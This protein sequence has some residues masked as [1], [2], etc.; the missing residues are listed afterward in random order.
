MATE[1]SQAQDAES[2][3]SATPEAIE[4]ASIGS[5]LQHLVADVRTLAEAELAYYQTKLSV[6]MSAT[7]TVLMLF[8]AGLV[9]GITGAIALILGLLLIMT[10]YWGPVAATALLS[11]AALL[12]TTILVNMAL[13]RA[14]KLP[15]DENDQ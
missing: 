8:G 1:N 5:Q 9:I 2:L 7:K 4:A 14:R 11:G 6:N 13:K 15:L 12:V 10:H 3:D